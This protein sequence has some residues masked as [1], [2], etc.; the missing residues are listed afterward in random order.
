[1]SAHSLAPGTPGGGVLQWASGTAQKV[2]RVALHHK[3]VL[4]WFY[5]RTP[6][7]LHTT[8]PSLFDLLVALL[9]P[10]SCHKGK[11]PAAKEYQLHKVLGR[12]PLGSLPTG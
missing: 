2:A 4:A 1:M 11:L 7:H 6:D 9:F 10:R 8:S 12:F 3:L 5:F